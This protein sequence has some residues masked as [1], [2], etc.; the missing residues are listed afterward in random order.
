MDK[1]VLTYQVLIYFRKS[2]PSPQPTWL[3]AQPGLPDFSWHNTPKRWK[4]Y[5]IAIKLS[6]AI[7]IYQMAVK[8]SDLFH[9]KTLQNLPNFGF[10]VWKYTIWQPWCSPAHK[11][12]PNHAPSPLPPSTFIG[13]SRKKFHTVGKHLFWD[14]MCSIMLLSRPLRVQAFVLGPIW[15][16]TKSLL[17][18]ACHGVPIQI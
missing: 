7:E 6:N 17:K 11:R 3:R 16:Q 1:T 13:F 12:A 8:Y 2:H 14:W 5:Q 15:R 18:S 10:L 9:S 4:M